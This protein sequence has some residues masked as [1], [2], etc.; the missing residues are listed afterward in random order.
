[1]ITEE[2]KQRTDYLISIKE[3]AH[4]LSVS[5]RQVWRFIAKGDLPSPVKVGR[6]SR[7]L[8]SDIRGY[9]ARIKSHREGLHK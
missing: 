8:E 5:P 1:M 2:E 3:T 7:F 4:R 9:I 6:A